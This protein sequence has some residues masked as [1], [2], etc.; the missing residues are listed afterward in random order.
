MPTLNFTA[1]L[2]RHVEAPEAQVTG[3]TVKQA[4][5]SY[6]SHHPAVRSYVL[7]NQGTVRH[8]VAIFINQSLIQDRHQLSD[9]VSPTDSILVVQALSGG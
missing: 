2:Q 3:Q 8:H 5:E 7:D 4:L 9:P 6:F 1:N